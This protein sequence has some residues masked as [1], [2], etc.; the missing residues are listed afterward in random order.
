MSP[1]PSLLQAEQPQLSQPFLLQEVFHPLDHFYGPV[2]DPLLHIHLFLVLGPPWLDTILQVGSHQ[3]TVNGQD[4][5]PRTVCHA[6]LD[7]AQDSVGLLGC[8]RK[9]PGHVELLVNQHPKVLLLRA[10]LTSFSTQPVF[11]LGIALT[12]VQ[13]L[14]L[15][16]VELHEVHMGPPLQPVQVPLDGIPSLQCVNHTTQLGVISRLAEGALNPTVH[17]TN[18]E[19]QQCWSQY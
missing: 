7:A 12:H 3:S 11:V 18:K 5:L 17:V 13:D 4:H 14:A 9:L 6:S 10:A 19:V 16:L 15:G 1:E 8:E 2:V